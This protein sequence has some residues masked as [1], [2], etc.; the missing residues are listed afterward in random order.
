MVTEPTTDSELSVTLP[1]T[2]SEWLDERANALDIEREALLVQ[3]LETHRSTA[4]MD[5]DGL[6]SLFESVDAAGPD[7]GSTIDDLD[8]RVDKIDEQADGVD[9]RVDNLDGR[10]DGVDSRVDDVEAALE[11]NVEDIRSRVLQ[12]R[13][14]VEGRAPADHSHKE[15]S[16]LADRLE[17]TSA[18]V[19]EIAEQTDDVSEEVW[20]LSTEMSTTDDRLETLESKVDRLARVI[21]DNKKRGNADAAA[22]TELNELRRAANRTRTTTADCANCNTPVQIGLLSE[23]A[24]PHC[25]RRLR[26]LETPDSMFR[27]FKTPVLT[28]GD[29]H[30]EAE[31][32]DE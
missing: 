5:D 4:E 27:L 30:D 21:V 11:R 29:A 15:T 9:E 18:E 2:L 13:D 6:S 3:L 10:V 22:T 8:E 31:T 17:A 26:G 12:L 14:A 20:W 1:P 32:S 7:V 25:D 23:A 28:V 19:D 24:C 16:V